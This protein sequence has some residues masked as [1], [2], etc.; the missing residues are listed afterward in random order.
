[1][2]AHHHNIAVPCLCGG[3]AQIFAPSGNDHS[4]WTIYCSNDDRKKIAD[5]DT[6]ENAIIGWN[7]D[8]A[9]DLYAL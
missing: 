9:L 6:M 8:Q 7:E 1:M 3:K 5:A 2:E 4:R